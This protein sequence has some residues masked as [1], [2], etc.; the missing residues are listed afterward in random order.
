VKGAE[1]EG[2]IANLFTLSDLLVGRG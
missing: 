2:R 1:E